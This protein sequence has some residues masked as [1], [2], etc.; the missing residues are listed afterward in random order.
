MEK[1]K[2]VQL[3]KSPEILE[4][5]RVVD[6]TVFLAGPLCGALLSDIGAEVIKV[7][8]KGQGDNYRGLVTDH[9][10]NMMLPDGKQ[11]EFEYCNRNKKGLA[12][13][14]KT[15][16]GREILYQ[17]VE[18]SDVFISN[19]RLE[20]L[21]R[22][23]L[24]YDTLARYNPK[25]VYVSG[26]GY[27]MKGPDRNEPSHDLMGLLRS[28]IMFYGDEKN[29][30]PLQSVWGI[31]DTLLG[32][33]MSYAVIA[34]LLARERKGIGQSIHVSHLGSTVSLIGM[35]LWLTSVGKPLARP[36]RSKP[37]NAGYNYYVCKDGRLIAIVTAQEKQWV[38]LCQVLGRP[39]L[40]KDPRFD[41]YKTRK[42]NSLELAP[43]LDEVFATK[44]SEEWVK[45][46]KGKNVP[47]SRSNNW[48]EVLSDPQVIENEYIRQLDHPSIGPVG[49][50]GLAFNVTYSKT[51]ARLAGWAPELGQHTEE[52]LTEILGYSWD[53]ITKLKD[54]EVI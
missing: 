51:P 33:M 53:D 22:L 29:V 10:V 36:D 44:S 7:E 30:P 16:K 18:K 9:D 28:G 46:F 48:I 27:G 43:I 2:D 6:C 25:L 14:F 32:E 49:V 20:G 8:M 4:G 23:G 39:D 45:C 41:T 34:G 52:I 15:D 37:F 47:F 24:D 11:L 26:S 21:K 17:L 38:N 40:E 19:L 3:Q 50:P 31:C 5:I 54:A 42:E 1:A 35:Q 12:I 13:D